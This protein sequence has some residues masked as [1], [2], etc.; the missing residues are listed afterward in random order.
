MAFVVGAAA[1]VALLDYFSSKGQHLSIT[2]SISTSMSVSATTNVSTE[3]FS[4]LDVE[5]VIDIA[6]DPMTAAQTQAIVDACAQCQVAL[7]KIYKARS[8]LEGEAQARNPSYNAQEPN[9]EIKTMMTTGGWPPDVP[10]GAPQTSPTQAA[11][12]ACTAVCANVVVVG[13]FQQSTL[14]AKADCTVTNDI[15][16]SIQQNIQGQIS[17]YLKNQQDIVGQL[18]SAFTSN[19]EAISANLATTMSQNVT[20]NF[21]EDLSQAMSSMQS[22]TVTGSSIIASN[23]TQSFNGSMVGSL[24]VSNTVNDQLRQSASYSIAQ[25][26]LNKNDTI[27]DLSTD[28]LQ[29]I[30]TMSQLMEELATQIL[31][32]IGAVLAAVMLVIGSLYI[33]NK[34]FHSWASHAVGTA[35]DA[36]LEHYRLMQTNGDYRQQ[37]ARD[38]AQRHQHKLQV[39]AQQHQQHLEQMQAQADVNQRLTE[40]ELLLREQK[41]QLQAEADA[42]WF[43]YTPEQKQALVQKKLDEM[44]LSEKVSRAAGGFVG[45]VG[46]GAAYVA[47]AAH[48]VFL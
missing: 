13:V 23:V 18:E 3:C 42:R 34:N 1:G 5:Q 6:P 4:A 48:G 25:S 47:A 21:I 9:P 29:V 8:D 30:N 32:I 7:R 46:T 11:L 22:F 31:I 39:A 35:A 16:N 38:E 44:P 40:N 24:N 15:S 41:A 12:G 10:Q 26:L 28:F 36:E 37:V 19:S 45:G 43:T 20:N 17:A 2:D 33:F 27:G 14:T